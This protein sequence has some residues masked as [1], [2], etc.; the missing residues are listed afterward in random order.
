MC[1]HK[2]ANASNAEGRKQTKKGKRSHGEGVETLNEESGRE[3]ERGGG[4]AT[5]FTLK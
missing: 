4:K 3:G 1:V 5:I 2:R